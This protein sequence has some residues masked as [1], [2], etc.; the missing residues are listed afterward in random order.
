MVL[1]F[2][3]NSLVAGLAWGLV[4]ALV[5]SLIADG[6]IADM[7]ADE[8]DDEFLNSETAS[9][10]FKFGI[11]IFMVVFGLLLIGPIAGFIFQTMTAQATILGLDSKVA[12]WLLA[13]V[14][15]LLLD[16]AVFVTG[17]PYPMEKIIMNT[18]TFV[19]LGLLLSLL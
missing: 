14:I 9:M 2:N 11:P 17:T 7:R 18:W 12:Y 16:V 8:P 4:I 10:L 19:S 13:L 6:M 3:T 15:S 5:F 1:V